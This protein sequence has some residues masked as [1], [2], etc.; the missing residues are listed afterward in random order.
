[1]KNLL[2]NIGKK[3]KR[4]FIHK[5]NSKK[6]DKILKDYYLLINKNRKFFQSNPRLNMMVNIYDK[7]NTERKNHIIK[8]ANQFIRDNTN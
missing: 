7:M 8:K 2:I 1:M 5:L 3:S 4:A 6:K